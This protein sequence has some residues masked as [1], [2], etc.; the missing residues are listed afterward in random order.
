MGIKSLTPPT[1]VIRNIGATQNLK[2]Y[3]SLLSSNHPFYIVSHHISLE[4]LQINAPSSSVVTLSSKESSF[5]LAELL[6]KRYLAEKHDSI[7]AIG[8]GFIL[9]LA[10]L[11]TLLISFPQKK[12][13]EFEGVNLSHLPNKI[14]TIAI[15]STIGSSSEATSLAYLWDHSFERVFRIDDSTLHFTL[16]L[17]DPIASKNSPTEGVISLSGRA[18]ESTLS[19]KSDRTSF[20]YAIG[21]LELVDRYV[22]RMGFDLEAHLN[23]VTANYLASMA[24]NISGGTLSHA[25]AVALHQLFGLSYSIGMAIL[26]P[27]TLR[28]EKLYCEEAFSALKSSLAIEEDLI[29]WVETK[30]K[31]ITPPVPTRLFDAPVSIKPEELRRVATAAFNSYD[32]LTTRKE[33]PVDHLVQL[34]EASY[35]GYRADLSAFRR[36]RG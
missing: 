26:L 6:K 29:E 2:E 16:L 34:L 35:W 19:S 31:S 8:G 13:V 32:I 15:P 23:I 21:A 18:I 7:V 25:L 10:K 30:I 9:D 24:S 27:H 5:A 33:I 20:S 14:P 1:T 3:L 12:M 11:V 17:L 4:A 36:K 28:Y 22:N